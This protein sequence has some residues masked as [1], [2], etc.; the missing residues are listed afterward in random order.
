MRLLN[1]LEFVDTTNKYTATKCINCNKTSPAAKEGEA[2]VCP[3]CGKSKIVKDPYTK[4][5]MNCGSQNLGT[6]NKCAVCGETDL[7]S[8]AKVPGQK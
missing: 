3:E 7:I 5:C 1:L 8:P 2:P 4:V 6:T